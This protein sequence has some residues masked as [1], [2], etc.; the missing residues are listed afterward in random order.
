MD[1]IDRSFEHLHERLEVAV[2]HLMIPLAV[3]EVEAM[4]AAVVSIGFSLRF[5]DWDQLP[6]EAHGWVRQLAKVCAVTSTDM[7]SSNGSLRRRVERLPEADRAE[8]TRCL[9]E[10]YRYVT[11]RVL[12]EHQATLSRLTLP[13]FL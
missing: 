13:E 5:L 3:D 1:S 11:S 10:L 7:L 4:A 12:R 2:H 6:E 8:F 9:W